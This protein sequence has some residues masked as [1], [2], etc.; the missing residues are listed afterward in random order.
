MGRAL[1]EPQIHVAYAPR[2]AGVLCAAF[3][4]VQD[5]DVFG[6]FTGARGRQYPANF[7][8]LE[9]YYSPDETIYHRSV[10]DDVH[11]RWI[12]IL[13]EGEAPTEITNPAPA[14]S[15]H[16]LE[17]MQDVFVNE[18]L[19]YRYDPMHEHE[20]AELHGRGLPVMD[21]NIRPW[22]LTKLHTDGP[23]WT[24]TSPGADVNVI[25]FLSRCWELDYTPA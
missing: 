5:K 9:A 6:W 1:A 11:G 4:F 25:E 21:V 20:A 24:H 18:W 22:K 19:F 16:E 3:W 7:F 10:K 8:M 23:V 13:K 14:A 12:T 17:R 2:G 15:C